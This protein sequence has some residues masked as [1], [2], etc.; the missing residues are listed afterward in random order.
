MAIL[1]ADTAVRLGGKSSTQHI[2]GMTLDIS[3][4]KTLEPLLSSVMAC[5]DYAC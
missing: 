4:N 1:V 2:C 5:A 3:H